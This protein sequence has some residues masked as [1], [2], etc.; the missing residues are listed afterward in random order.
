MNNAGYGVG[1]G[2][3]VPASQNASLSRKAQ[4]EIFFFSTFMVLTVTVRELLFCHSVDHL[5][6]SV[7]DTLTD[8][9]ISISATC[10]LRNSFAHFCKLELIKMFVAS[11]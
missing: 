11:D 2:Q 6:V 7:G 1:E 4:M 8:Y 3:I 5:W 9:H 10:F